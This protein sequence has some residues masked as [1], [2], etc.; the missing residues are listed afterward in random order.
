MFLAFAALFPVRPQ[1]HVKQKKSQVFC[2]CFVLCL[3]SH[4]QAMCNPAS[5]PAHF[6]QTFFA[7]V[8]NT[9]MRKI[10]YKT[11]AKHF[12]FLQNFYF[13]CSCGLTAKLGRLPTSKLLA[14]VGPGSDVLPV[15]QPTATKQLN[16]SMGYK[17]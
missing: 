3:T 14:I 1:L 16:N 15:T 11:S 5:V 2:K 7:N 8:L 9:V 4:L 6:S 10:K 13:A 17:D 12:F